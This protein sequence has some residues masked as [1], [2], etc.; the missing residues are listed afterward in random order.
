MSYSFLYSWLAYGH[1]F[2][3][4][5]NRTNTLWFRNLVF[6][7]WIKLWVGNHQPRGGPCLLTRKCG[8]QNPLKLPQSVAN[9]SC[10]IQQI[11]SDIDSRKISPWTL[12]D[13]IVVGGWLDA[14]HPQMGDFTP[15]HYVVRVTPISCSWT[16]NMLCKLFMA[17]HLQAHMQPFYLALDLALLFKFYPC[18]N[19]PYPIKCPRKILMHQTSQNFI[20]DLFSVHFSSVAYFCMHN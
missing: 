13:G 6:Y 5:G 10:N 20:L 2:P 18:L 1:W 14:K 16:S 19:Q 8:S 17:S 12:D 9:T 4:T 3:G 11:Y 7:D 15:N